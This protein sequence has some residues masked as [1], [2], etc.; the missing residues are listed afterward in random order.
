MIIFCNMIDNPQDLEKFDLIYATYKTALYKLAY[1]IAKNQCDAEDIMQISMIKLI[2]VLYKIPKEEILSPSCRSL[3]ISIVRNTALDLLRRRKH[4]PI[5]VE[6]LDDSGL[7][8]AEDIYFRSEEL[9]A[10]IKYI[11][12]LQENHRE[13]L[14]LRI[15]YQLSSKETAEIM[16]I[17]EANV[18]TMLGR[19]RKQLHKK[20]KENNN[21]K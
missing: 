10:V 15:F 8:S 17:N 20:F 19:A 7:E 6:T 3:L 11:G 16:C 14:R 12:E 18:N 2:H 4:I 1:S 9:K 21:G 13:V 5:P